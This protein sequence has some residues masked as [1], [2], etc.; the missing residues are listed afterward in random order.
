MTVDLIKLL[1]N[2]KFGALSI[3]DS[4]DKVIQEIGN[5]IDESVENLSN[6]IYKYGNVEITFGIND[7]I[8]SVYI[9][10]ENTDLDNRIKIKDYEKMR[11]IELLN[12]KEILNSFKIKINR[13]NFVDKEKTEGILK[14]P[15]HI[16]VSFKDNIVTSFSICDTSRL[17]F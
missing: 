17:V 13:E 11:S 9:E 3:G 14:L 5:P 8:A 2:G 6:K 10:N 1:S 15:N 16:M 4:K 12:L 7:E